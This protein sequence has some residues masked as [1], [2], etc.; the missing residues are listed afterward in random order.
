MAA[1]AAVVEGLPA[2]ASP[3]C[4]HAAYSGTVRCSRRSSS[5]G[6]WRSDAVDAIDTDAVT[7]ALPGADLLWVETVTNP[8]MGVVDV[9]AVVEAAHTA[10]L[11]VVVD[12]TF[13][14]PLGSAR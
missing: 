1:V 12:A 6:G 3:S 5:S 8:L 9:P 13:S 10:R 7:A 14:T 4:P 2:G 11:A